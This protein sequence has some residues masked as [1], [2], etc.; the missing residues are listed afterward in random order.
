MHPTIFLTALI[1]HITS[2][3]IGLL[4]GTAAMAAKKSGKIHRLAGK[5][6]FFAMVGVFVS[7][8]YMSIVKDN[9]FLLLVGFFSIYLAATGYRILSLK[10]LHLKTIKPALVDWTIGIV[11]LL[12]GA[13]MLCFA[14]VLLFRQNQFSIVIGVF[15]LL[16]CWLGY[17][18]IR[19]FSHFPAA[20]THWIESHGLRMGGAYAATVTAFVVVNIQVQLQWILWIL[21]AV[22][23]VPLAKR[24]VNMFITPAKPARTAA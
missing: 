5:I 11:G 17:R 16:A 15:G 12:S 9:L 21:P 18:D 6:F 8:I 10:K 14:V 23:I 24:M 22:V 3:S 13:A 1:I 7:S 19:K 2:G 4:S 20:K